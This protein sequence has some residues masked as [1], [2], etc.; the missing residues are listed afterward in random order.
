MM[1]NIY[2]S[3][4]IAVMI[5]IILWELIAINKKIKQNQRANS[6]EIDNLY[7]ILKGKVDR[8]GGRKWIR[9]LLYKHFNVVPNVKYEE[10][11]IAL[12]KDTETNRFSLIFKSNDNLLPHINNLAKHKEL[13]RLTLKL[14]EEGLNEI[15]RVWEPYGRDSSIRK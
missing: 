3:Y 7:K 15:W 14:L 8:K 10:K 1:F 4:F 13:N 2:P 12:R 9:E 6:Y 5:L 11:K